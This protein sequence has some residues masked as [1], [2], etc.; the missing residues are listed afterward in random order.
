V[1]DLTQVLSPESLTQQAAVCLFVQRTQAIQPA[2]HVTPTN[3]R[4]IAEICVQLD[5][6]PLAIELAAAR[7]KL[8]PP[9]ALLK[10]LSHRLEVLTGGAQ[11]LPV[12]QQ[13]L[14]NTFQWSYDLLTAEEQRLFRWLSIF[15]GG[16]TLEAANAVCMADREQA[17]HLLDG[18]ASLLDKS[19]VQQVE[20]EEEEPRLVML[21]TLREFGL[22]CL[23]RHGELEAAGQAH[24]HYY[25]EFAE[26]VEPHLFGSEQLLWYDHLERELDNLRAILQAATTGGKEVVEVALRLASALRLFWAGRGYLREGRSFLERLLASNQVIA[27]PIRLKALSALGTILWV[28]SDALRIALVADEALALAREQGDQYHMTRAMIQQGVVMMLD[29][30][31]YAETQVW[32]EEA[33]SIA[34]ALGDRHLLVIALLSLGRLALYQQDAPQVVA[35]LEEALIQCRA[36]GEKLV[37]SMTLVGLAQA[38]MS[39]NHSV[40]A[41][42]LLK[43][44]LTIYQ[45]LGNTWGIAL[46]LNLLGQLAVQQGEISQ[47][48]IF[49]ADSA[50]LASEIG[51]R[52]NV[53]R[54]CLLLANLATLREEF[55]A[56]RQ[57]YEE[58]LSIALE[59]GYTSFIASGLKGLGCVA[60]GQGLSR[61]AAVLWG[62]ADPLHESRSATISQALSDRMVALV[63]TQLGEPAFE[64]ALA[65]GRSMTPAQALAS[66]GSFPPNASQWLSTNPAALTTPPTRQSTSMLRL[67]AREVEV[68]C[69]VVQGLS[70]AQVAE[71]L[72]ISPRTV[73][74]HL[75]SIYSKLG[76]SSRSAATRYAIENKL[77]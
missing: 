68:L 69:L 12:R 76:V 75:T 65:Q 42:T 5:G 24:M 23:E 52:R 46:V 43:E 37:M 1:P 67:T 48:E 7:S 62:A 57:R 45:A 64:E 41:D 50:R 44:G 2:F 21:E 56:A 35:W 19:L 11:D 55:G 49:L 47:A 15:V 26:Q 73:N 8:L 9:Q 63:R 4:V 13:T 3:A 77:V 31:D 17:I 40:R 30:R 39:Q 18:V 38:E 25:L 34:R 58:A 20:R 70:N 32:L 16:C 6:L 22:E 14:L 66:H 72:V 59:I 71:Q 54:S 36:I 27:A 53:A 28:Q 33:L 51:D 60:A 61:W 74:W 10:R 29:R